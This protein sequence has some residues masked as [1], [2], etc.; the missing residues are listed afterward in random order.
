VIVSPSLLMLSIEVIQ[1]VVKDALMRG[2]AHLI[3]AEVMKLM[4]DVA[5]L[6]DRVRKLQPHVLL[7]IKDIDLIRSFTDTVTKR[8][9]KIEALELG[10]P[11][12]KGVADDKM[13]DDNRAVQGS[14]SLRLRVV[15]E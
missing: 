10:A 3:Q 9:A 5:R 8:G 6:D 11:D 2:Q 15:E 1:A 12:G 4:Q 7:A 13:A 14:G